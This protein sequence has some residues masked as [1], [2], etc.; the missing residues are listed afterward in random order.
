MRTIRGTRPKLGLV[1]IGLFALGLLAAA[2][3]VAFGAAEEPTGGAVTAPKARPGMARLADPKLPPGFRSLSHQGC[4]RCHGRVHY[5]WKLSMHS[6]SWVDP[7]VQE[8][9]QHYGRPDSCRDCHQPFVGSRSTAEG[10]PA[11]PGFAAALAGEGIT[12]AVCHVRDGVILA[13]HEGGSRTP[14][15]KPPHPV[16]YAPEMNESRFCADCHQSVESDRPMYDTFREWEASP[17]AKEGIR[18]QD[19]HLPK[20]PRVDRTGALVPYHTHAFLGSH[21][22]LTLMEALEVDLRTDRFRYERGQT[23]RATVTLTNTGAG[24]KVPTGHPL[25]GIEVSVGVA[26]ASGEFVSVETRWLRR[27]VTSLVDATEGEDTRLAPGET[28]AVE[29]AAVLPAEGEGQFFLT[30]QLTYHLLPPVL[31]QKL[32]V[33]SEIVS[34]TYDSRVDPLLAN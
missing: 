13:P 20:R 7:E 31:V 24:H 34:R 11:A 25:H 32:G 8:I 1:T 3:G 23:V 14:D 19:C 22:D 26:D 29:L 12:C 27:G 15:S 5:G 4:V 21:T 28:L 16:R 33:P 2:G 10:K 30:V 6:V 17:A 9:W 18:C